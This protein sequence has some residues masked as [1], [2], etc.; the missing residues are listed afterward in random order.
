MTTT[1]TSHR[2]TGS[3]QTSEVRRSCG[4][5]LKPQPTAVA[6]YLFGPKPKPTILCYSHTVEKKPT[7]V[8]EFWKSFLPVWGDYLTHVSDKD[9]AHVINN[10]HL[11]VGES[12]NQKSFKKATSNLSMNREVGWRER[13]HLYWYTKLV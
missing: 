10:G 2:R 1:G 4:N 8:A 7:C 13:D 11:N 6:I 3:R 5:V 12:P 9:E